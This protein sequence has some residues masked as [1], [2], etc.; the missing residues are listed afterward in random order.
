M[1]YRSAVLYRTPS[2]YQPGTFDLQYRNVNQY[3]NNYQYRLGIDDPIVETAV[4]VDVAVLTVTV[5]NTD[6]GSAV[7]VLVP[8]IDVYPV[9]LNNDFSEGLE[10]GH[11]VSFTLVDTG[12][13]TDTQLQGIAVYS[14]DNINYWYGSQQAY[15]NDLDYRTEKA[16]RGVGA[17]P[18][19]EQAVQADTGSG[20]DIT[21]SFDNAITVTEAIAFLEAH[22]IDLSQADT[23]AGAD[24]YV[25]LIL[26]SEE[27]AEGTDL[28]I[29][30]DRTFVGYGDDMQIT[31]I[32]SNLTGDPSEHFSYLAVNRY[33]ATPS[34]FKVR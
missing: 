18:N 15:R 23:S 27:L 21:V 32:H 20:S 34:R 13:S 28:D 31:D 11:D 26:L 14:S 24:V 22:G 6:S 8:T 4:G 12:S 16:Y 2:H 10:A 9:W 3:R 19:I 33:R 17:H 7:D 5:T 29:G 25:S 30:G 1:D